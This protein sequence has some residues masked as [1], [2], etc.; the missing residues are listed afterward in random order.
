MPLNFRGFF[1]WCKFG[2]R[3]LK[4]PG[5]RW[6]YLFTDIPNCACY[7]LLGVPAVV[8]DWRRLLTRPETIETVWGKVPVGE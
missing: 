5:H 8:P 3:M 6:G 4:R 2:S 1:H 7:Y